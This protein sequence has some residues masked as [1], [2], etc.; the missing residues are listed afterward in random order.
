MKRSHFFG[1]AATGCSVTISTS[2][3]DGAETPIDFRRGGFPEP[4]KDSSACVL[5]C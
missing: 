1:S 2:G 5:S 4:F 3:A